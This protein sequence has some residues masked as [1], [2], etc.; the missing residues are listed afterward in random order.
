VIWA[1]GSPVTEEAEAAFWDVAG[2]LAWQLY[3]M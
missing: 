2:R 3:C 1:N